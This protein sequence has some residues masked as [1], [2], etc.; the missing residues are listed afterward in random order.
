M[1]KVY[2][3]SPKEAQKL[4]ESLPEAMAYK[5]LSQTAKVVMLEV[6]DVK[7]V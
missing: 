6:M 1:S 7:R 2:I 3:L 4:I 5:I